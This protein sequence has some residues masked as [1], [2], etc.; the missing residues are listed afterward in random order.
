M[1]LWKKNQSREH[2]QVAHTKMRRG[3]SSASELFGKLKT[4]LE[5]IDNIKSYKNQDLFH[6]VNGC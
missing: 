4:F 6:F 1:H 2:L 3:V 5:M